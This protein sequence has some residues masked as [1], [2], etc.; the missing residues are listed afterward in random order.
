V[1]SLL[2]Q[3][4]CIWF[5]GDSRIVQRNSQGRTIE[6]LTVSISF[7]SKVRSEDW[8]QEQGLDYNFWCKF[9]V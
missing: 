7:K 2:T 5:E 9:V 1:E 3:D 8:S 6:D 4:P